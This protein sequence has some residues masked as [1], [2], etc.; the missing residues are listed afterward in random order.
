MAR[1]SALIGILC[2]VLALLQPLTIG[3][4]GDRGITPELVLFAAAVA[5]FVLSATVWV[6]EL[7]SRA[8]R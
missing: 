5:C 1:L 8:E 3:G 2:L 7:R 6:I 4:P